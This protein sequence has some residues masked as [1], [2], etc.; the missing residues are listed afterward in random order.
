MIA[1]LRSFP[2]RALVRGDGA[3]DRIVPPTGFTARLTLFAAAAMA[4]LSVLALAV[5]VGS[6]RLA[7][8]WD[9]ALDGTATVRITAPADQQATQVAAALRVLETTPGVVSAERLSDAQL[10]GLLAPWLGTGLDLSA[11]PIPRLIAVET[12]PGGDFDPEGLRL[13]LA[14]EVPGAVLD[15]HGRWRAPLAEAAQRL[16]LLSW[17]AAIV[18]LASVAAM[19]TL[20]AQAALSANAQ[21]IAV[22]RLVGATDQ[23]IATA[24]VRRF[25]ARAFLGGSV[26]A[27]IGV[28]LLALIPSTQDGAGLLT[29]L[30]FAGWSWLW[31]LLIPFLIGLTALVA[32]ARAA[33]SALQGL[34]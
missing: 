24:F 18:I 13:R 1:T 32:T 34:T 4:F 12:A 15:D 33:R 29:E 6:G 3:A 30:G 21:V 31:P 16:R 2:W 25:T 19:V 27:F 22:L 8:R 11:L 10:T 28:V 23:Y 14:G 9:A 7:A 5:S 26:G 20:A 17:A